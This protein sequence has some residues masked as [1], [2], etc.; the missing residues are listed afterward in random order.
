M[1][2]Y[3]KV[4]QGKGEYIYTVGFSQPSET[5][6]DWTALEDF[7]TE[8]EARKLVNYLNGGNSH[9]NCYINEA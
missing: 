8:R 5:T 1:H 7:N 3:R 4:P 2:T 9:V 6:N